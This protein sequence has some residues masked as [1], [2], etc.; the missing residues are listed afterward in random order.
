[1]SANR[2]NDEISFETRGPLGLITMTRPKALNAL[3]LSMIREMQP[4]LDRWAADPAVA[5]VAIRGAR[6]CPNSPT[7]SCTLSIAN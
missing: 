4:Q 2:A 3:T 7:R 5:A 1:M 6:P